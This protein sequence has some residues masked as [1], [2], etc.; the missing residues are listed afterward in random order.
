MDISKMNLE[1]KIARLSN[2]EKVY[3]LNWIDRALSENADQ[4]KHPKQDGKA[5]PLKKVK[6]K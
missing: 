6:V 4:N 2:A 5:K 3:I 1:E